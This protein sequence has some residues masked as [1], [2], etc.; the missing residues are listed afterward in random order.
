MSFVPPKDILIKY[1]SLR[2]GFTPTEEY[3]AISI[4]D[5][6]LGYTCQLEGKLLWFFNMFVYY[7]VR[8]LFQCAIF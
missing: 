5:V 7:P 6:K 1:P 2:N 8:S 4:F 3:G